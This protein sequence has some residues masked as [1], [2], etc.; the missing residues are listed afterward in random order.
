MNPIYALRYAELTKEAL[1]EL[2]PD[3][4]ETYQA[5]YDA[6]AERIA[7]LDEAIQATISTIPEQNR[8]LLTYHDSFA[9]FAPRYGMTVIGAIQPSDFSEP[10]AREVADL[11]TQIREQEIAAVFG[12]EVFPSPVL[13]QIAREAGAVFI[14]TLRDDDLPG[15]PGDENHSYFGMMV[16]DVITMTAA[17]GGD[18]SAITGFDTS[19]V[20]NIE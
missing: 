9:Y 14:D 6:F 16:E 5:N 15:D 1:R 20:S 18:T 4:A 19:N 13:D 2:N 12:S 10:S 7:A 17:L 8:R 11:I 3:N